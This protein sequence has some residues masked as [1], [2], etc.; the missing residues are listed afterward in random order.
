M[1]SNIAIGDTYFFDATGF[2][3][4]NAMYRIAA[5]TVFSILTGPK[6]NYEEGSLL[7]EAMNA[8][9]AEIRSLNEILVNWCRGADDLAMNDISATDRENVKDLLDK[10]LHRNKGVRSMYELGC[11]E[12]DGIF[13]ELSA[14]GIEQKFNNIF[15]FLDTMQNYV[16][17]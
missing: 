2:F 13:K 17:S 9:I 3:N 15:L 5:H 6:V 1:T 16:K 7:T 12:F 11:S 14:S 4:A 10:I 8:N